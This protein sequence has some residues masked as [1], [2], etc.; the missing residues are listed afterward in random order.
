VGMWRSEWCFELGE[1]K[2]LARAK[3]CGVGAWRAVVLV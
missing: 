1:V 3:D 2:V